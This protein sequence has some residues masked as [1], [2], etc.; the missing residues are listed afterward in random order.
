METRLD[1]TREYSVSIG[2]GD[3]NDYDDSF[4]KIPLGSMGLSI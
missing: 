1:H 4:G 3:G 2:G